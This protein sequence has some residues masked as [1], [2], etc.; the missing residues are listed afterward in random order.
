MTLNEIISGRYSCRSYS[1]ALPSGE[2]IGAL[3][4]AARLAPSA[5]N[6]QPW[7]FAVIGPD[8][9]AGRE[10]VLAAYPREWTA[11]APY[12]IVVCGVPGEAWVRP[13]DGRNHVDIDV[14]IA[15]EHICLKATELG[16]G[17]CWICHFD[18][19][20]LTVGLGLPQGTVPKVIIPVGYPA[21]GLA[22]PEKKRKTADEILIKR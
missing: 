13:H 3:L 22:T 15:S 14:A 9:T 21:D 2:Q 20:L 10:A 12:F 19:A 17:T 8:D 5:C 11:G 16:L 4:E 1:P 6:R 18:P 7:R